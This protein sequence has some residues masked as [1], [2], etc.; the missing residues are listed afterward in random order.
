[1]MCYDVFMRTT[2]TLDPDVAQEL[3]KKV[4]TEHLTLKEAVNS[5]L[6]AGLR[7][8]KSEPT[9]PFKVEP[10]SLGLRPGIDPNKLSQ[11]LDDMDVEEYV[12]KLGK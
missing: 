10:F 3:K 7:Q 4:A 2:L 9:V 1:M 8:S 5:T 6:R 11:L 12:R